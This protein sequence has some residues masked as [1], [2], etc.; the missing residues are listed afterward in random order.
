M[1]N[2]SFRFGDSG[3]L[4]LSEAIL[5]YRR[6]EPLRFSDSRTAHEGPLTELATC[7]SVDHVRGQAVVGAGRPLGVADAERFFHSLTG[8]S[9]SVVYIPSQI[10]AHSRNM[11]IWW[12]PAGVERIWFK[13]KDKILNRLNGKKVVHPPLLF[14]ADSSGLRV[15][16][17]DQNER[18]GLDSKLYLAPYFNLSESGVLCRG[19]ANFPRSIRFDDHKKWEA[20]FF[21]SAFTHSNVVGKLTRHPKGHRGLW[22]EMSKKTQFPA[23]YLMPSKFRSIQQLLN[24]L[25]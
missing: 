18:P 17:L 8:K 23:H 14:C 11:M 25:I 7:H 5:I 6:K 22:K 13:T 9:N 4:I 3:E 20:G 15:F 21:N 19:S 24:Q 1:E 10:V 16:A 12:R 2:V